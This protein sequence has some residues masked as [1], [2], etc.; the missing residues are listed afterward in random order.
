LSPSY[1]IT[2]PSGWPSWQKSIF[3][4]EPRRADF[5]TK[6]STRIMKLFLV[7][8]SHALAE[9][10]DPRRPLSAQGRETTRRVAAFF[11]ENGALASVRAIWHSPLLRAKET[12]ELLIA[13]L[14]LDALLVEAPGLLPEDDPAW[15]ADRL[16]QADQTVLIVGHEP[17]LG[18]L[19]TLLVRG[20]VRPVGFDIK[21]TAVLALEKG[22]GNHKKS[23]RSCWRVRWH[24]SP[25]LLN[26]PG[27]R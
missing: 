19:A 6:A 8:H 24:F 3:W 13:G 20:K 1:P 23:G 25:E 18:S 10:D 21:K 12:A 11:Q 4:L 15:V 5:Q 9:T 2:S 22:G 17:Q 7:R 26:A 27:P 16:D 14:G